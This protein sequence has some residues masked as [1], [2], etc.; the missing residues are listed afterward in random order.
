LTR[1]C[2][3]S[4]WRVGL[5]LQRTLVSLGQPE[6]SVRRILLSA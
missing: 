2:S 6:R 1:K 4:E 3:L 5:I